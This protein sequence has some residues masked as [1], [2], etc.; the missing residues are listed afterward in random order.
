MKVIRYIL[1]LLLLLNF[2]YFGCNRIGN[3][4][5]TF[6]IDF[7]STVPCYEQQW[8]CGEWQSLNKK[9]DDKEYLILKNPPSGKILYESVCGECSSLRVIDPDNDEF[10]TILSYEGRISNC[11]HIWKPGTHSWSSEPIEAGDILF[12]IYKHRLYSVL[13][14]VISVDYVLDDSNTYFPHGKLTYEVAEV[15]YPKESINNIKWKELPW[16]KIFSDENE[17]QIGEKKIYLSILPSSESERVRDVEGILFL[18]YDHYYGFLGEPEQKL[19]Q[20]SAYIAIVHK[21]DLKEDNVIDIANYR[22]KT[23]EDGLGNSCNSK[24]IFKD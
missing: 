15:K 8:D 24:Y 7:H 11:K 4:E 17:I 21:S 19:V 18:A 16:K 10:R 3:K 22:F 6:L 1:F 5:A 23:W 14:D 13:I 12:V 2:F 9:I 20:P